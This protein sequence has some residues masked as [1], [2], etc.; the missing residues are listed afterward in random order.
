MPE[1][2]P[3]TAENKAGMEFTSNGP[4]PMVRES[5]FGEFIKDWIDEK[6]MN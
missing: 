6:A 1:W 5:E 4:V 3:Y 2:K